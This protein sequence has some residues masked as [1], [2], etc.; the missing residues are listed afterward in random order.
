MSPSPLPTTS[1]P[2]LPRHR[3]LSAAAFRD[4]YLVP[5]RPVVLEGLFDDAPLMRTWTFDHFAQRC[6]AAEVRTAAYQAGFAAPRVRRMR[7]A[8]YVAWIADDGWRRDWPRDYPA[9]YLEQWMGLDPLWGAYQG[10][11][12]GDYQVPAHFANHSDFLPRRLKVGISTQLF[13]GPAG[14]IAWLHQDA[15]ATHAWSLQIRGCKRWVFFAPEQGPDLYDRD[16]RAQ[17]DPDAPDYARFPRFRGATPRHEV[18]QRPGD[19]VFVPSRW[20]HHVTSLEPSI[21]LS[22]NFTDATTTG[23]YLRALVGS[24]P[25]LLRHALNPPPWTTV[26]Q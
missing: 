22:G 13:L 1:P 15:Y 6:G 12:A 23:A 7:L 9:P 11:V 24:V 2:P 8:E 18:I 3:A 25:K 5:R 21:S 4:A 20:W 26:P 14:T 17:V 16:G 19:V 10:V